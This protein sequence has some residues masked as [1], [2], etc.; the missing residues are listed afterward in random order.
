MNESPKLWDAVVVGAGP[1]G[2][3]AAAAL[4][5]AGRSVLLLDRDAE[6]RFK[7]GE[8][9]L[10]RSLP[11]FDAIGVKEKIAAAG[12][13]KK[14][15]A[16][17]WNEVSGG[18]RH[19]VF[20]EADRQHPMAWQVQ[21]QKFD[22]LLAE[23]AASCG[24]VLRRGVVV[25]ELLLSGERATGV[26]L[27]GPNGKEDVAAKVVVDATGQAALVATRFK[28]REGDPRLRRAALYAHYR[29][30][31]R[32]DGDRAGDILLP[33]RDGVWFW[34]IPFGDG[35]TSVGAVFDPSV[36]SPKGATPADRLDDMIS[37]SPKMQEFLAKAERLTDVKGASDY[38]ITAARFCGD[39]WVL[40]GDAATF[41]DPVFSTG[42]HLGVSAGLRLARVI[43]ASLA[44]KGR[45]DG[46]DFAR[47]ERVTRKMVARFRPFV[48][49]FYDPEFARMFC[50]KEPFAVFRRSVTS[51]L[52]GNVERPNAWR[53]FWTWAT[54]TV[55][56]FEK[57]FGGNGTAQR[58][59]S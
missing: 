29:G 37:R 49:G 51:I 47:Y 55:F 30:V 38:S 46:T 40:A 54:L 58:A 10:P 2:C 8:S 7:I 36:E 21:R 42:V 3:V 12:F 26:R 17:F 19:V 41:I 45:V 34:L 52:A 31:W 27:A 53:R 15:G 13:Q 59:E 56:A 57:R 43:D 24:A 35:T 50:S 28:M 5:R 6:P 22:G 1:S 9:L 33:F 16:H 14:Y 4:A 20:G 18:E 44:S 32:D 25:E 11:I 39:G 23:H 48:Y